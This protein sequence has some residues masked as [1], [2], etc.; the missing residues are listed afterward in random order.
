MREGEA[1]AR[2][3][4]ASRIVPWRAVAPVPDALPQGEPGGVGNLWAEDAQDR[5]FRR[6][7]CPRKMKFSG[8]RVL[9][10]F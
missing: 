1:I 3:L 9:R 2:P 6:F 5:P 7:F 10:I 8:Q 4:A